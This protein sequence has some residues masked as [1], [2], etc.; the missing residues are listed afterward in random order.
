MAMTSD[1]GLRR[2]TAISNA[3]CH[4]PSHAPAYNLAVVIDLWSRVV[5]PSCAHDREVVMRLTNIMLN[6]GSFKQ[7]I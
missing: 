2:D 3:S 5:S 4:S 6:K 7:V 1:R